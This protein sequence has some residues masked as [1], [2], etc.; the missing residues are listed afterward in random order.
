MSNF[1]VCFK[2]L[3][4][5]LLLLLVTLILPM[6]ILPIQLS[7]FDDT[8]QGF[9]NAKP[10]VYIINK[11]VENDLNSEEK[12]ALIEG[13]EAEKEKQIKGKDKKTEEKPNIEIKDEK[14]NITKHF[15]KYLYSKTIVSE[16][17]QEGEELK[18]ILENALYLDQISM[19]IEIPENFRADILAGKTPEI[20]TNS[21]SF[22]SADLAKLIIDKY[23]RNID[24]LNDGQID[25]I[26]LIDSIDKIVYSE[27]ETKAFSSNQNAQMEKAKFVFS[28]AG[29]SIVSAVLTIDLIILYY[30]NLPPVKK[31]IDI[32]KEK[33]YVHKIKVFISMCLV[34]AMIILAYILANYLFVNINITTS[35]KGL[36][37]GLNSF[38]FGI[39]IMSLAYLL[40]HFI[41]TIGGA[42]GITVVI[43]LSFSFLAGAFVPRELLPDVTVKISKF[44]PSYYYV[45]NVI[46]IASAEK[47]NSSTL[48]LIYKNLGFICI[49]TVIFLILGF[50]CSKIKKRKYE[51][52]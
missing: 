30:Y 29:Y 48:N 46:Q 33:P 8:N 6:I 24:L 11:D 4:K 21:N 50:I 25:E 34:T 45:D 26:S 9:V 13:N 18:S 17:D 51:Q 39:S 16:F 12:K 32:S 1:K 3:R 20:I 49:F 52:K 40:S 37:F 22:S 14:S 31:R 35:L 36:L 44:L 41:K 2:I 19:I 47:I 43:A 38:I 7:M 10:Y 28:F 27:V 5:N 42:S 23:M 15:L